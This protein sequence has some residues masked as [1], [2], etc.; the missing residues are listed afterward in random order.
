MN[1]DDL[2]LRYVYGGLL[3]RLFGSP[4][5]ALDAAMSQFGR[6]ML[7]DATS[8]VPE[9]IKMG[10]KIAKG[11]GVSEDYFHYVIYRNRQSWPVVGKLADALAVAKDLV[12]DAGRPPS[13]KNLS[14]DQ[15]DAQVDT[16]VQVFARWANTD[17]K[18]KLHT[19]LWKHASKHA[20]TLIRKLDQDVTP[21]EMTKYL[22]L[23][24]AERLKTNTL[25]FSN[26]YLLNAIIQLL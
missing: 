11:H 20:K 2:A 10:S 7:A 23:K 8:L 18:K 15:D 19:M 6:D 24:T 22:I 9:I 1:A 16:A 5:D 12:M 4:D 14:L 13:M 25:M 21:A 17:I 26:S 3:E